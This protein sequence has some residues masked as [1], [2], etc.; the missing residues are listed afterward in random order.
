MVKC[1]KENMHPTQFMLDK[2]THK[3]LRIAALEDGITMTEAL[4]EAVALW[5]KA[6]KEKQQL[7]K[8]EG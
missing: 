4:R 5:L 7:K 1:K 6:R 8:R 3:R 2:E